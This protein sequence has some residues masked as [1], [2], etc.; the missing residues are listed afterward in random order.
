MELD[1]T[2]NSVTR[3]SLLPGNQSPR[4]AD[5]YQQSYS[6]SQALIGQI[7]NLADGVSLTTQAAGQ[8][9]TGTS[10]RLHFY[11][12]A[13]KGCRGIVFT[14]GVWMGSRKSLSGLYLRNHEDRKLI[15]VGTLG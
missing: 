12:T 13:L 11:S 8:L 6:R 1:G 4:A 14:H 2:I 15:L 9:I 3:D 10:D 5:F 7:S